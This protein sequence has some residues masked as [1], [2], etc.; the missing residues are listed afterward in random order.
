MENQATRQLESRPFIR[1]RGRLARKA[2]ERFDQP[3]VYR[4]YL[5]RFWAEDSAL[6]GQRVFR[7]SLEGPGDNRPYG[8]ANLESLAAFIR[9][10]MDQFDARQTGRGGIG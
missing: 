6:D 10:E 9:A 5:L 8:F 1:P 7:F 2:M 3:A 4:A